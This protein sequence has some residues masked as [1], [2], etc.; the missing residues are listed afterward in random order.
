MNGPCP[1]SGA[2]AIFPLAPLKA[3]RR[4][5]ITGRQGTEPDLDGGW[6]TIPAERAKNGLVHRVC[7]LVHCFGPCSGEKSC[8]V[9]M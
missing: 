4:G 9:W 2:R 3:Q 8:P 7:G 6:R 1:S 5:E